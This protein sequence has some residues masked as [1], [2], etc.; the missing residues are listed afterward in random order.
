M[1]SILSIQPP[2]EKKKTEFEENY[3]RCVL[4]VRDICVSLLL[5]KFILSIFVVFILSLFTTA[6]GDE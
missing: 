3:S 5:V 2:I 4:L 6:T 1:S